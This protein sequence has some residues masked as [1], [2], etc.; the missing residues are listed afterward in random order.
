MAINIFSKLNSTR[1]LF[2]LFLILS[3]NIVSAFSEQFTFDELNFTM[4]IPEGFTLTDASQNG[5]SFFFETKLMPVKFALKFYDTEIYSDSKTTISETIKQLNAKG[6]IEDVNWY[7]RN[8]NISSFQFVMPDQKLYSGWA[9]SVQVPLKDNPKVKTNILILTYADSQISRDCDQY[10]L[11]ILD[12]VY[13]CRE[14]FRRAGPVTTFAFPQTKPSPVT[15]NIGGKT[16]S[17]TVDEDAI[18]RSKF[19]LEREY[20]V[21]RIYANQK[22]WKEAWQRYYRQLFRESFSAFDTVSTDIYKALL[23]SAQK[24]NFSHPEIEILQMLLDWVQDM[25][26]E[27]D[28]KNQDFTVP[29][30]AIQGYGCD[31]D[32]RSMLMCIILEH[33]GIKTELFISREYSHAVFGAAVNVQGAAINIDNM[34]Y[35]LGETT[36]KVNFGLIAQEQSDTKKWIEVDLP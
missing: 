27:R 9:F 24:A 25:Q 1:K 16:I 7:G 12:N 19:V 23:P 22:N 17:S 3:L 8:C 4:D 2:I 15:L 6:T 31:C 35:V 11:S 21:L 18:E 26:Y 34:D 10:M 36:A 13:L 30:A 14:D 29:V 28:H 20:A 5:D 32:S 33:L